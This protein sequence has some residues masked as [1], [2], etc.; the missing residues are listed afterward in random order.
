MLIFHYAVMVRLVRFLGLGGMVLCIIAGC[1]TTPSIEPKEPANHRASPV[2]SVFALALA[3]VTEDGQDHELER[4][5]SKLTD[6]EVLMLAAKTQGADNFSSLLVKGRITAKKA[7]V[8]AHF[9]SKLDNKSAEVQLSNIVFRKNIADSLIYKN[10]SP[11]SL[12]QRKHALKLCVDKRPAL[13]NDLFLPDATFDVAAFKEIFDAASSSGKTAIAQQI[14][15][16]VQRALVDFAIAHGAS[17]KALFKQLYATMADN[18]AKRLMRSWLFDGLYKDPARRV[19][20]LR[21]VVDPADPWGLLV[22]LEHDIYESRNPH[23]PQLSFV[24]SFLYVLTKQTI[25]ANTDADYNNLLPVA[26]DIKNHLGAAYQPHIEMSVY[27]EP[28]KSIVRTLEEVLHATRPGFAS[29]FLDTPD[30]GKALITAAQEP[31]AAVSNAQLRQL[32]DR[33]I[34]NH[35]LA[36]EAADYN[37]PV[38]GAGGPYPDMLMHALLK[39]SISSDV[40]HIVRGLL[41]SVRTAPGSQ[42]LVEQQ[43]MQPGVGLTPLEL[44]LGDRAVHG[45]VDDINALKQLRRLIIAHARAADVEALFAAKPNLLKSLVQSYHDDR[46]DSGTQDFRNLYQKLT[47]SREVMRTSLLIAST[48]DGTFFDIIDALTAAADPYGLVHGLDRDIYQ[49]PLDGAWA[50]GTLLYVLARIVVAAAVDV[51]D[52]QLLNKLKKPSAAIK[53]SFMRLGKDYEIYATT[54]TSDGAQQ[55]IAPLNSALGVVKEALQNRLAISL[56]PINGREVLNLDP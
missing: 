35:N 50:R 46:L 28:P 38:A 13:I 42:A 39:R 25:A 44:A 43:L 1:D 48:H 34:T 22:G 56:K 23:Q 14:S 33:L 8:L 20:A 55:G 9:I 40:V 5:F 31:A 19:L 26:R 16:P 37:D 6:Q 21:D 29:V 4:E 17:G 7:D 54:D 2:D 15:Y 24:G 3:C 53:A 52:P 45:V 47:T 32:F 49:F 12:A 18:S 30:V 27:G 10:N 11:E 36:R 51:G 41:A